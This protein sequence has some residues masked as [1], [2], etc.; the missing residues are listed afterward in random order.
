MILSFHSISSMYKYLKTNQRQ[1][2]AHHHLAVLATTVYIHVLP[3]SFYNWSTSYCLGTVNKNEVPFNSF[4]SYVWHNLHQRLQPQHY[5][6]EQS[7]VF[8]SFLDSCFPPCLVSADFP[9]S[10][11][12]TYDALMSLY[13]CV[14][15][16]SFVCLLVSS[17][18]RQM[19]MALCR[20]RC[21]SCILSVTENIILSRNIRSFI[22]PQL[23]KFARDL[24]S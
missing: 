10:P 1:N 15:L 5:S 11:L 3:L 8:H 13:Q 19:F 17:C 14:P 7:L 12:Q 23:H 18:A 4:S 20:S 24:K 22:S 21:S 16:P 6:L 2:N 9:Q